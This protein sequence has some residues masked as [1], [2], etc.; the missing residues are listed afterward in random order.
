M[1]LL[2]R[3]NTITAVAVLAAIVVFYALGAYTD[4][5]DTIRYGALIAIGV[6]LPLLLTDGYSS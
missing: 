2:T 1:D 3:D 4:A 5:G 6:L